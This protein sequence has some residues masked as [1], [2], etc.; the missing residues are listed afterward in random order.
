M[1]FSQCSS[2]LVEEL[3]N[4][5][6][7]VFLWAHPQSFLNSLGVMIAPASSFFSFAKKK[8][9]AGARSGEWEGVGD[10]LDSSFARY[11]ST[12]LAEWTGALS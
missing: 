5:S 2:H 3:A 7:M 6:L 11:S 10:H 12:S 9:S 4:S 8:K 1:H